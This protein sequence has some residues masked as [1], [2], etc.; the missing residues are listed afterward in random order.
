MNQEELTA[1]LEQQTAQVTAIKT[2]LDKVST[3]VNAASAAQLAAIEQLKIELANVQLSDAAVAAIGNLDASIQAVAG[4]VTA[5]DA[6]N[7]DA[8]VA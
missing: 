2:Q 7:P 3:E 8:P 5:L 6:L 1:K 4:V